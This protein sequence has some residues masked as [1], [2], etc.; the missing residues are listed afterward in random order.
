MF[1]WDQ[2]RVHLAWTGR[3][4][5]DSGPQTSSHV[6]ASPARSLHG[7][8]VSCCHDTEAPCRSHDP[9]QTPQTSFPHHLLP[10]QACLGQGRAVCLGSGSCPRPSCGPLPLAPVQSPRTSQLYVWE[11]LWVES[12]P[13]CLAGIYVQP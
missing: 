8:V 6:P 12:A 10:D 13:W 4:C 9:R 5:P 3:L 7:A 2:N 1:P 11:A